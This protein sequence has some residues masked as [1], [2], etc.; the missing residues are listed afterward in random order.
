MSR[1]AASWLALS[2]WVLSVVLVGLSAPLYLSISPSDGIVLRAVD[3][4]F[5][6]VQVVV[7]STVGALLMARRPG[8]RIGWILAI[9]GLAIAV[10]DVAG[11]YSEFS[12]VQSQGTLPG[13]VWAA[14]FVSWI[15][16]V[17]A[18]PALTFLLLIFPD[19]R[20]PSG[21]WRPV[22]WLS[23]AAIGTIALFMASVALSAVSIGARY[24]RADAGER[25]QIK[26][27][28]FA[29]T[30]AAAGWVG[31]SLTYGGEGTLVVAINLFQ[32]VSIIG[33]PI[34][35]GIAV[36]KYRLYAIDV[37]INRTL[38]Y[39]A[40]TGTLVAVY[41]G[42][43]ATTQAIFRVLTGQEQPQLAIVASTLAIAALFNPLRGLI[44]SFIDRR[45]Y[46]R[47][48]DAAKTLEAFSAKLRDETD[49]EALGVELVGV[50]SETMQPSHVS[51]WLRPDPA[52]EARRSTLG[53]FEDEEE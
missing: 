28:A 17:G 36:L 25:Q 1:R 41:F 50:V 2:L 9:A 23:V 21:L 13:T 31:L 44:Q 27:F 34:A 12:L 53:P 51:L 37:L 26:W 47:K 20:L 10:T 33:V 7:F 6:I 32:T 18:G 15:W 4:V 49:L 45:F 40:L 29:G 42:G 30:F 11:A 24:R 3:T 52:P 43:V 14:W 22:G 46:R 19:G 16:I 39:G 35:V 8:N 38:V 5:A 48:Y